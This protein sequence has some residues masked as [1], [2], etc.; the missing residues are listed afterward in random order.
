M[1][2]MGY[3]AFLDPPKE[4][5]LEAIQKLSEYGVTTKILTGDNDIVTQSILEL[6]GFEN[7]HVVL[8]SDI[9]AMSDVELQEVKYLRSFCEIITNPKTTYCSYA[10]RPW[11]HCWLYG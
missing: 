11:S 3:L 1:V 6:I 5:F 8:G 9:D 4:S 2:L 10:S 7:D